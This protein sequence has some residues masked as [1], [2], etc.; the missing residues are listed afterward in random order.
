MLNKDQL[1]PMITTGEVPDQVLHNHKH[2]KHKFKNKNQKK[3]GIL[4]ADQLNKKK[5]KK[6]KKKM[7]GEQPTPE[8]NNLKKKKKT[9]LNLEIKIKKAVK[10]WQ[11]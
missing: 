5:R 8:N 6:N 10:Q 1:L 11:T 3:N 2:N 9:V 7:N 4:E